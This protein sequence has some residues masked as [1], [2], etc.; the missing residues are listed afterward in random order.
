M[1]FEDEKKITLDLDLVSITK[2][3]RE[4]NRIRRN[5]LKRQANLINQQNDHSNY[6]NEIYN[7]DNIYFKKDENTTNSFNPSLKNINK[8][9]NNIDQIRINDDINVNNSILFITD[10]KNK[11]DNRL[12]RSPTFEDCVKYSKNK[13]EN[14]LFSHKDWK[15]KRVLWVIFLIMS[16]SLCSYM[17]IKT[18]I[19]YS[20]YEVITKIRVFND[21]VN[22][23][24]NFFLL[25]F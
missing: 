17:I 6:S 22:L 21:K 4:N 2:I 3:I 24:K 25:K 14:I 15:Y 11:N 13:N 19:D 18:L 23:R 1:D 9:S 8:E 5:K 12:V 7:F 20:G 16:T 10:K